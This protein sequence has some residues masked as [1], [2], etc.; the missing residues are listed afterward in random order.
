[1]SLL[2]RMKEIENAEGMHREDFAM[3]IGIRYT[4]LRNVIGG[5]AKVRMEDIEAI[6][7]AFPQYKHWLVFGEELPVCGQISPMN[8]N[9]SKAKNQKTY[10]RELKNG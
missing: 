6:A 1:L 2:D 4:R 7:T 9:V 10:K 5:Q 8:K 3:K